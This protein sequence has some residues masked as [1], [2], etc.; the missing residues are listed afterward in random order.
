MKTI[1]ITIEASSPQDTHKCTVDPS[2][3]VNPPAIQYFK[4]IEYALFGKKQ[5]RD[6][7]KTEI[8]KHIVTCL[9]S[10]DYPNPPICS[11]RKARK[12]ANEHV[13]S[14]LEKLKHTTK[15]TTRVNV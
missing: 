7:R 1:T 13:G 15:T 12:L 4:G 8:I 6:D 9:S 10:K 3:V 14:L 11:E 5:P 2:V